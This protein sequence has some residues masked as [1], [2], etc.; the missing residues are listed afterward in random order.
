M[1]KWL[2]VQGLNHLDAKLNLGRQAAIDNNNW[3]I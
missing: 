2:V 3:F 1:D